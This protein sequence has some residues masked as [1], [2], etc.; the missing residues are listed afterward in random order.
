MEITI[1]PSALAD[2]ERLASITLIPAV[3]IAAAL[4][5]SGL[6][7]SQHPAVLEFWQQMP[8]AG[9]WPQIGGIH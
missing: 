7:G 6:Y 3:E 8:G 4:V 5:L 1:D 9:R 2:L